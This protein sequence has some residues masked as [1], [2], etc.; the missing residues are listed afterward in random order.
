MVAVKQLSV[1]SHQG[2][3]QFVAEIATVSAVQHRNLVK[4]YGCCIEADKRLL[5]YEFLENKSLDQAL[6][7]KK[8]LIIDWAKRFEI[9]VGVARGLT[10]LHEESRLRI[11]HR[12]VKA[13]N[14]LL[15]GNLIPKISDFGLAKLYDDKKT[16]ISTR[17]AG[18]IGYLAPEYAMR[19]HLTEKADVFG[20][21]VVAL[22]IVSGRPNSYP[23]LEQHKIYLLDW[24]WCLH[25]NNRELEMVDPELSEF[26]KEEVKRVIGVALLCTQTSPALRPSMSRVVAMLTGDVEVGAVTSKPGYLIDWKFDDITS[27]IDTP[28]TEEPDSSLYASTTAGDER[29]WIKAGPPPSATDLDCQLKQQQV[30]L[31]LYSLFTLAL[32]AATF[33]P[34]SSDLHLLSTLGILCSDFQPSPR[35]WL[36]GPCLSL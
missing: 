34:A 4:L 36:N 19:G 6:F 20:F 33:G 14:I 12:D 30:K 23:S 25:E 13:S 21:G 5:V 1:A 11:V 16:H 22:E 10:Y 29:E 24:T 9:C 8:H 18:T 7:G 3:S 17:V 15:D 28:S 31:T 32:D 35:R 27:F 2:K 26:S